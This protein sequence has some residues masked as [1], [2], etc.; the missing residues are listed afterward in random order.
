MQTE[1]PAIL[2]QREKLKRLVLDRDNANQNYLKA[3][4][5]QYAQGGN[6]QQTAAKLEAT[7]EEYDQAVMRM[8]QCKVCL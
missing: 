8:E 1:I 4:K 6:P 7:K 5:A 3:N 2:K